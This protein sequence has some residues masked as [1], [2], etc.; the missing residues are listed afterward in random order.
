MPDGLSAN[1][2]PARQG[3]PRAC[4][5]QKEDIEWLNAKVRPR[6]PQPDRTGGWDKHRH[7]FDV[8]AQ[9]PRDP[10]GNPQ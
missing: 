8:A 2:K 7:G 5:R 10:G 6:H 1:Q 3:K 9:P 4:H